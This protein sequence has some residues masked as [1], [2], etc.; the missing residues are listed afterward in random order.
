MKVCFISLNVNCDK[1]KKT[2]NGGPAN[3]LPIYPVYETVEMFI[4]VFCV[5]TA[6]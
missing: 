1:M 4:D 2:G 3:G 6:A 5:E